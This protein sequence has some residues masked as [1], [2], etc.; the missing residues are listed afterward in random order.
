MDIK[1]Q[2][3]EAMK[4]LNNPVSAG[5]LEKL[6]GLDRKEIDKAKQII[7][8]FDNAKKE[9][10]GVIKLNGKMIDMPVVLRAMR[11]LRIAETTLE[12]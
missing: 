11:I 8:A 4:K 7:D 5:D 1:N 2:V 10:L 6:T 9:G 12:E 3:Y